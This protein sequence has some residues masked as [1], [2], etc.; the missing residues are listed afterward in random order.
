MGQSAKTLTLEVRNGPCSG[1]LEIVSRS[2]IGIQ[3]T[4]RNGVSILALYYSSGWCLHFIFGV[5]LTN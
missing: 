1:Q 5:V 2:S 4:W 3:L